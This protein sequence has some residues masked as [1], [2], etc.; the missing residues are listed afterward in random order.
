MPIVHVIDDEDQVRRAA[1]FLLRSAGYDVRG[2]ASGA[3][4]L[5]LV[6]RAEVGCILL[7][8]RMPEMGGLEVQA[9][10]NARGVT[11]P[12]ILLAGHGDVGAA[13]A[14]MKAGAVDFVEKPIDERR[15]LPAIDAACRKR[16]AP[17]AAATAGD[18]DGRARVGNL[19]AREQDVLRGLVRGLANKQIAHELGISPRTVEVH[20]ANVMGKLGVR[21]L[22]EALRVAFAAGFSAEAPPG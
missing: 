3:E 19:T 9:Q 20:R 6:G 18:E 15:L 11:M 13:V 7:D 10:L 12:V 17:G 22:P 21:S 2:Y 14:A 1:T 8:M 5:D 4:F 16:P